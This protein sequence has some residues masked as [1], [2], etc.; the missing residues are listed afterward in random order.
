MTE[1]ER[2]FNCVE[3]RIYYKKNTK[4]TYE[5][6]I[7]DKPPPIPSVYLVVWRHTTEEPSASHSH[8]LRWSPSSF[9]HKSHREIW[10][11]DRIH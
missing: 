11:A 10:S 8:E 1:T 2:L 3:L 5:T 7:F 4:Y 9:W 6:P